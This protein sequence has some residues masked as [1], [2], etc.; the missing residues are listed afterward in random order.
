MN[1]RYFAL[2]GLVLLT[3]AS[4]A[5]QEYENH[6]FTANVGGGFT[7]PAYNTGLRHD[8]GWNI[9]TGAGVNFFGSHLGVNGEFMFNS[10]G[11]N[12]ATLQAL[13]FPGGNTHVWSFTVDPVLRLNPRGKVDFYLTGGYGVYHRYVAFTQPTTAVFNAFDPFF[14]VFYQVGV[15]ANQV[16]LSYSTTKGGVNGGG[17]VSMRLGHS[18][19]KIYA[20][21][22]Y[23]QMY[24]RTPTTFVPVTI[25]F[26][27]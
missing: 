20:E 9:G 19:A 5:A 17:G 25:G 3:G 24:T 21:A 23:H 12:S 1:R 26:R 4:L 2:A 27:F 10:M 18:R 11:I 13:E 15:P 6:F 8:D 14:G 16:L 7:V 22:R